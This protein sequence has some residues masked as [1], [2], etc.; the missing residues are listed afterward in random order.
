MKYDMRFDDIVEMEEEAAAGDE[1][2]M[3]ALALTYLNGEDGEPVNPEKAYKWYSELAD[4]G[5]AIA[6]YNT[7]LFM[8][9]GFGTRRNFAKAS[10]MM[11][12]VADIGD[13]DAFE[14]AQDY[15]KMADA[16]KKANGGDAQAQADLAKGL[17]KLGGS[18]E[19]AGEGNDYKESVKWAK[20]AVEQECPDGYWVMA[21]AYQHGRGVAENMKKA[22][23]MY[24]KGAE[25]G[26]AECQHSLGCEYMVGQNLKKDEKKAFGLIKKSAEQGY[27][28]AMKDLGRCY[29]VGNGTKQN[30]KNAV[31]WYEK[32][33]EIEG[34]DE[35]A[36][37]V[38][39]IKAKDYLDSCNYQVPTA[40]LF[41]QDDNASDDNKSGDFLS[42]LT[43]PWF[44]KNGKF[45]YA[46][47]LEGQHTF[48]DS[49]N[50]AGNNSM[51][52]AGALAEA[53]G[54]E[55]ELFEGLSIMYTPEMSC[56]F[57]QLCFYD[58]EDSNLQKYGNKILETPIDDFDLVSTAHDMA[59][60]FRVSK[61]AFN[62]NDDI[63]QD[64]LGGFLDTDKF[65]KFRSFAWTFTAY[66]QKEKTN[67]ISIDFETIEEMVDYIELRQGL[68][69]T[70]DRYAPVLCSGD[71]WMNLYIPDG[72]ADNTVKQFLKAANKEMKADP[73]AK[74]FAV[75]S[76]NGL[77]KE[78]D[79]LYPAIRA[80]Y[81]ELESNRKRKD[82]LEGGVADVLCA[83][84][85]LTC[86]ARGPM[87]SQEG[88]SRSWIYPDEYVENEW[89]K[90]YDKLI[91]K[92]AT[93]AVKG[94]TFV[95]TGVEGL[96][97]W[98]DIKQK[99]EKMGG[100][101]R[102]AISGKTD[103]L[104]CNPKDAG[105]AKIRSVL[106]QKKKGHPITM[107]L[108][109][110][111]IKAIKFTP[112][113]LESVG[114]GFTDA[115]LIN[116][117]DAKLKEVKRTN[118]TYSSKPEKKSDIFNLTYEEGNLA[119]AKDYVFE[120]PDG[121]IIKPNEGDRDFV[122]Y[123]PNPEDPDDDGIAPISVYAVKTSIS[124][125]EQEEHAKKIRQL[126]FE[127]KATLCRM[128]MDKMPTDLLGMKTWSFEYARK[129]LPG[130]IHI[131]L[132]DDF[133]TVMVTVIINNKTVAIRFG[134]S[135]YRNS[136]KKKFEKLITDLLDH[137]YPEGSA[138]AKNAK[139]GK[140]KTTSK[141][142]GTKPPKNKVSD[143]E[144][145]DG[146]EAIGY[147]V[148]KADG[149]KQTAY[150]WNG[151][152][153]DGYDRSINIF[154][155]YKDITKLLET[156]DKREIDVSNVDD[157]YANDIG[158]QITVDFLDVS[159][160]AVLRIGKKK[161]TFDM[162]NR[163]DK[164][165]FSECLEE[166][167]YVANTEDRIDKGVF[168][169]A[170]KKKTIVAWI[171]A[172]TEI[173][174]YLVYKGIA[175]ELYA[176]Y[177]ET[178]GVLVKV[179]KTGLI[180]AKIV[181]GEERPDLICDCF[182]MG[183]QMLRPYVDEMYGL[184]KPAARPEFSPER[185][186]EIEKAEQE[187]WLEFDRIQQ[188]K[189]EQEKARKQAEKEERERKKAEREEAARKKAEQERKA[190][191]KAEA[192]QRKGEERKKV[193]DGV[194][195]ECDTM[196]NE[197]KAYLDSEIE[198]R[199]NAIKAEK[200]AFIEDLT[201]QKEEMTKELNS[202]GIFSIKKKKEL[203]KS[204]ELLAKRLDRL[205]SVDVISQE[206]KALVDRKT[207]AVARYRN[208][209]DEYIGKRFLN[210]KRN[211]KLV[212]KYEDQGEAF[213]ISMPRFKKDSSVLNVQEKR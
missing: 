205:E 185:R 126:S 184:T 196:V 80:I 93:I 14:A 31:K 30:L 76:L 180:R 18:L 82:R 134:I 106:E 95:F 198:A 167:G 200:E 129:D 176:R 86:A 47:P 104:V 133:L 142:A 208:E 6:M 25:L 192:E 177:D 197:Y 132:C 17:M 59:E 26:N 110:D 135:G 111:F 157:P 202:L 41:S 21:L 183:E 3:E 55:R 156:K 74:D 105:E 212:N 109:E 117:A 77:R 125:A 145:G 150:V 174:D 165:S 127:D 4:R 201:R 98:P 56:A 85:T 29:Q 13:P 161:S 44:D 170:K 89:H 94:K 155:D 160:I 51:D 164:R 137:V 37:L 28:L 172:L 32:A 168:N 11:S 46:E 43:T 84:C 124:K 96:D 194:L 141:K 81:D 10:E 9:K 88:C 68:N 163:D 153:V 115:P 207:N 57:E 90:K 42:W 16:L 39:T 144:S 182:L 83:W 61:A 143:T 99:L 181:Q 209:L 64:I 191:E 45:P 173:R 193:Y 113:N 15:K 12:K 92:N 139:S 23:E 22:I 136:Q 199:L 70:A 189:A 102:T 20:K 175:Q 148:S 119:I 75:K 78:L 195:A 114:M 108:L 151:Y 101:A 213:G 100:F 187:K 204:L 33:L 2:A 63:E 67:P 210:S 211:I 87:I 65:N 121:F 107:V 128:L 73:K 188:E 69:F 146:S 38:R 48:L 123:I 7:A 154:M 24:E 52:W 58:D 120:L 116:H 179:T 159:Q 50:N 72:V 169:D 162:Y 130:A 206:R 79:Y 158:Y 138:K 53:F 40:D 97:A 140:S 34:D 1:K 152:L 186:E 91:T 190:K 171:W 66:C 36:A 147:T 166:Y 118:K 71:D 62:I 54:A 203:K 8:A 27:V 19:Q 178:A 149:S 112:K 103:Y 131:T 60:L 49:V 122:A 5:N 35:I